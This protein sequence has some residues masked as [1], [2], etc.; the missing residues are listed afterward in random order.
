V[1]DAE[2]LRAAAER[3]VAGLPTTPEIV[4]AEVRAAGY[5]VREDQ[6]DPGLHRFFDRT[7][8]GQAR[9]V[10]MLIVRRGVITYAE[11]IHASD[12]RPLVLPLWPADDEA[13]HEQSLRRLLDAIR[14]DRIER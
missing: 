10:G 6:H 1:T 2:E 5:R 4:L 8:R 14:D 11:W 9:L 13:A 12:D 3:L 7:A